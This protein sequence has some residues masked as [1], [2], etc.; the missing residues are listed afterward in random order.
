M[1]KFSSLLL[2]VLMNT[3]VFAQEGDAKVNV[4]IT[5]DTTTAAGFPWLWVIIGLVVL[6]LLVVLLGGSRGGTDRVVE[7]RTVIKD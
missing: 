6:I 5:K 7:K 2:L 3:L 1:K 4:D